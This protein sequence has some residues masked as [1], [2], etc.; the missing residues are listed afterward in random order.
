MP[1]R[2]PALCAV[3]LMLVPAGCAMPTVNPDPGLT[4]VR[5]VIVAKELSGPAFSAFYSGIQ[6]RRR[7]VVRS[8]GAWAALWSEATAYLSPAP[9]VPPFDFSSGML[10]VASMGARP[11]GGYAIGIDSV[12]SLGGTIHA[13][14]LE[15]SPGAEC[16]VTGAIT[17]PVIAV[18]IA[19]SNMPVEFHTRN[20]VRS[21]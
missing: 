14:V 3:T 7:V 10:L 16:G 4:T 6:D 1:N 19:R 12:Y 21:C 20:A 2:L 11:S 18:R 8:A 13:V 9:P 5:Q 17:N 15:T